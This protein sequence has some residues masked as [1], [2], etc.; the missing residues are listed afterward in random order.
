MDHPGPGRPVDLSALSPGHRGGGRGQGTVP[1]SQRRARPLGRPPSQRPCLDL[2]EGQDPLAQRYGIELARAVSPVPIENPPL[3]PHEE[4]EGQRLSS[5]ASSESQ[6]A[7]LPPLPPNAA[8]QPTHAEQEGSGFGRD[9]GILEEDRLTGSRSLDSAPAAQATSALFGGADVSSTAGAS[10]GATNSRSKAWEM[11]RI[12]PMSSS[13][14]SG[15]RD[16]APSD[17]AIS[18]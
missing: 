13:N 18:G 10:N 5:P 4:V 11:T 1:G 3:L 12:W 2:Y 8:S 15:K 14:C 7:H 6:I 17:R 16:W 9:N